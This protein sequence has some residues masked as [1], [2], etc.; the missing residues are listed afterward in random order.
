MSK[1]PIVD[2]CGYDEQGCLNEMFKKQANATPNAVAVIN[3][4]GSVVNYLYYYYKFQ[5]I[6]NNY[7]FFNFRSHLKN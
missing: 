4:D 7:F 5:L 2:M 3:I 6:I 1:V